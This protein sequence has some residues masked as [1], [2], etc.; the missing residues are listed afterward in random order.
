IAVTMVPSVTQLNSGKPLAY[1]ATVTNLGPAAYSPTL[2]DTLPGAMTF[3]SATA[4]QGS[5]SGTAVIS[6][7]LGNVA[8]GSSATVTLNVTPSAAGTF[9]N[10]SSIDAGTIDPDP[11]NN[12]STV[13]V[14]V[15]PAGQPPIEWMGGT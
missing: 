8:A 10:T 11:G 12:S 3:V 15:L 4:S 7:A 1:I 14:T 6:C 13:A 5:C 9:S 2:K